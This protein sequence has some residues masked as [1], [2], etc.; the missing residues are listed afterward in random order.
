MITFYRNAVILP[1]KTP[2]AIEW[3]KAVA[4]HIKKTT[5]VEVHVGVPVG[6]NPNRIGW[7]VGYESLAA[8]EA[9][10]AKMTADPKYWDL[11]NKGSDLVMAGSVHDEMWR[12]I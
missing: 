10:M 11:V 6:G 5:G 7:S 12:S 3:A 8:L 4:A 1:G 9:Q 2:K